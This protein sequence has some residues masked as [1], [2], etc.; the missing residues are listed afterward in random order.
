MLFLVQLIFAHL[1]P[2][3]RVN[4]I[5][6]GFRI[7]VL[8]PSLWFHARLSDIIAALSERSVAQQALS[9]VEHNGFASL[10][11]DIKLVGR[12]I[13]RAVIVSHCC[14]P[15][16]TNSKKHHGSSLLHKSRRWLGSSLGALMAH[17]MTPWDFKS[18]TVFWKV[19]IILW[20]AQ[21][22]YSLLVLVS[23]AA[24]IIILENPRVKRCYLFNVP[25]LPV[26]IAEVSNIYISVTVIVCWRI[27]QHYIIIYRKIFFSM[28]AKTC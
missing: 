17:I 20:I 14:A 5:S 18:P 28:I 1:F 11:C 25:K 10:F 6:A 16:E 3:I 23:G 12:N 22:R 4:R 27:N 21:E 2:L 24:R 9:W 8:P 19:K 26:L 13:T 7:V 15:L